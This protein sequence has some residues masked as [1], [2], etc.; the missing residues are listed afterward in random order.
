MWIVFLVLIAIICFGLLLI[1]KIIRQKKEKNKPSGEYRKK[2]NDV[3][4]NSKEKKESIFSKMFKKKEKSATNPQPL[5]AAIQP[6]NKQ[7]E[8]IEVLDLYPSKEEKIDEVNDEVLDLDDLF[9]TISM[10]AVNSDQ[11]FDFGLRRNDKK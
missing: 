1:L 8:E 10:T 5:N 9:K 11:D 6:L 3:I 7:E 2:E 4:N